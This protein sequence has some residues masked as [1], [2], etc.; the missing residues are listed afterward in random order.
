VAHAEFQ[1]IGL[2]KIKQWLKPDGV[3]YDIKNRI[4]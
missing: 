1:H 2:R 4:K 3:Y